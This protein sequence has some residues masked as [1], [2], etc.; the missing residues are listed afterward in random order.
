M[1]A[2]SLANVFND[3]KPF[4]EAAHPGA[5]LALN[6]AGS[7]QLLKQLTGGAVADVFASA[8]KPQMDAAVTAGLVDPAAVIE[9]ARNR[10]V[11]IFPKPNPA[12][13]QLMADL[14]RPGIKLVLAAKEVPAGQY[15]LEFLDKTASDPALPEGF[16]DGVLKNVVSYE[17]SVRAVL[18]KVA[19]GE[20]D[21]GIV[22]LTDVM[23][24]DGAKVEKVEIPEHLNVEV[25][26]LIAP[27]KQAPNP[28]LATAFIQL[29]TAVDGQKVLE[30]YYFELPAQ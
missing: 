13:I 11:I 5:T 24:P 22:Y 25:V 7:Q 21:A 19:L 2:S 6:Y 29:I 12:K 20:A 15:T 3:L 17:E 26:Y 16:K 10:L 9:F 8:G 18:T 4:Y 1:A 27:L 28:D 14:A 23:G 30:K